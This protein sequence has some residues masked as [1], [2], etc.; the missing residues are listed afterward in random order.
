MRLSF[1]LSLILS[2]ALGSS[3]LAQPKLFINDAQ[4]DF[5]TAPQGST[6]VNYFWFKSVGKDTARILQLKTGC[7]CATMPLPKKELA[8]GDSML[9]GFFWETQQKIGSSGKFP[10]VFVDG[11]EDPYRMNMQ[12]LVILRPDSAVPLAFKPFKAEF[13][14]MPSRSIDSVGFI[15]TNRG[16]DKLTLKVVSTVPP[17]YTYSLPDSLPPNG[18]ATGFVKV[19]PTA[20]DHEFKSSLT[21]EWT[22]ADKQTGR[23]TLPIRRKFLG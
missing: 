8:P 18:T 16:T 3:V 5:G 21:I 14:R 11:V 17:E 23:V 20:A 7:D 2:L 13:T 9:V 22:G 10:Y 1:T 12:A 6:I 19:A 15:L 4:Y